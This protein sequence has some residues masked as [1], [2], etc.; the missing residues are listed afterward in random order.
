M[1][2]LVNLVIFNEQEEVKFFVKADKVEITDFSINITFSPSNQFG[3]KMFDYLK[4]YAFKLLIDRNGYIIV[5]LTLDYWQC[6]EISDKSFSDEYFGGNDNLI[7]KILNI[8]KDSYISDRYFVTTYMDSYGNEHADIVTKVRCEYVGSEIMAKISSVRGSDT[9]YLNQGPAIDR[10]YKKVKSFY[11]LAEYI[12]KLLKFK[13]RAA[14]FI[15]SSI[16]E[17]SCKLVDF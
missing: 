11:D 4:G 5:G 13:S 8:I 15:I 17:I 14:S 9:F 6:N 7:D 3:R 10:H 12:V 2:N 16:D 1:A